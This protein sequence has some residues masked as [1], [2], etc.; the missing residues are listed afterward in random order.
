MRTINPRGSVA[1][2]G[3]Y[4]HGVAT[5]DALV[6]VSGQTP[7]AADGSVSP[8]PEQQ[9]RQIWANVN[10]VLTAAGLDVSDLV[11]VRTYLADRSHREINT[12]VRREVLGA[13]EPAL[14]VV[15]CD[16]FEPGWVAE[17]EAMARVPSSSLQPS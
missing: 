8:E 13:H 17:I 6:F 7:E 14:T 15:V 2:V 3:G 1:P 4:S 11:Q 5:G 12:K 10:A 9:L 16:L